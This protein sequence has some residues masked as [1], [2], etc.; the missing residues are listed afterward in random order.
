[1]KRIP[2]IITVPELIP[3]ETQHVDRA[4]ERM[5]TVIRRWPEQ[6]TGSL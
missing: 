2:E 6:K 5:K 1:M 3:G 4:P